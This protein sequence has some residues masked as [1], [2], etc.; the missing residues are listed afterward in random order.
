MIATA[1]AISD[2]PAYAG[3]DA[4][5][6]AL[7]NADDDINWD[8]TVVA[9]DGMARGPNADIPMAEV[10]TF[11]QDRTRFVVR[12]KVVETTTPHDY[13]EYSC[14]P[15][16]CVAVHPASDVAASVL[17]SLPVSSSYVF[18]YELDG[19]TPLQAGSTWGVSTGISKGGLNRPTASVPV[20]IWWY[21][22][23]PHEGFS[24]RAA[25][26]LAHE[27]V[28]TIQAKTEVAPYFCAPLTATSGLPSLAYESERLS[29][30]TDECYA[31]IGT[32]LP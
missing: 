3:L 7:R 8:V 18:L 23:N 9:M 4:D 21:N 13:T 1:P 31:K 27:I 20:D 6:V 12:V 16:I 32:N 19:R 5:D 22:N 2:D 11:I 26:I 30:L 10:V 28:N 25:S 14:G 29:K 17:A 15:G 24:S